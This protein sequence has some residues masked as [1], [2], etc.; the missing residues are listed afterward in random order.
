[1]VGKELTGVDVILKSTKVTKQHW[2]RRGAWMIRT[3]KIII[4]LMHTNNNVV[5]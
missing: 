1:M 4:I 3:I 2:G 5:T